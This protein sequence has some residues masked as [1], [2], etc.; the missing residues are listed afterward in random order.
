MKSQ[1]RWFSAA[2]RFKASAERS[3]QKAKSRTFGAGLRGCKF[4]TLEQRAML[5]TSPNI[6]LVMT[7]DQRLDTMFAMPIT[8]QLIGG[9]GTT[10]ENA[11]TVTSLCCPSRT[12]VFTGQYV[13][14]HGVVANDEPQ[15]GFEGFDDSSTLATWL[16]DAGYRTG[17]YGKF[18]NG[19]YATSPRNADPNNMY[20]PPGWDEWHAFLGSS[21]Y[22]FDLSENGVYTTYP[23]ANYSTDV[24]RDK[25]ADFIESGESNDD[26]PFFLYYSVKAPHTPANPAQRH[27]FEFDDIE[28]YRPPSFN[29]ADVSDKPAF[30][31]NQAPLTQAEIDAIDAFRENQ[32]ESLL[33]VDEAVGHLVETLQANGEWDNTIFVFMSDSGIQWGE[34]RWDVKGTGYEETIRIPMIIRDGRDPVQRTSDP[35]ALTIDIA[36]TLLEY[37][38]ISVSDHIDGQSLVPLISGQNPTWRNDFIV[39]HLDIG[40]QPPFVTLRSGDWSYMEY[41][42]GERE[43]YDLSADPYQ[44]QSLH[45]NPAYATVM[46]QLSARMAQLR[47][48]DT[49][50][51][52][53]TN[54]SVTPN[55]TNEGAV[56]IKAT[57][58]DI[59]TGGSEVRMPTFHIDSLGGIPQGFAMYPDDGLFDS[60]TENVTAVLTPEAFAALSVGTHTIYVRGRDTAG[61]WS[62]AVTATFIK[63]AEAPTQSYVSVSPLSIAHPE[64]STGFVEYQYTLTRTGVVTGTSTVD[65]T[66]FGSGSSPANTD[67][68]G[69]MFPIGTVTFAPGETTKSLVL[70]LAGDTV[71]ELDETFQVVFSNPSANTN[72]QTTSVGGII[73][74]DETLASTQGL[75]GEYFN[76]VALTEFVST[77]TDPTVNFTSGWNGGPPGTGVTADQNYS[78]RWSGEVEV[79]ASGA[80]TF[81]TTTNDGV[82]LWIDDQMVI[83]DWNIHIALENSATVNLTAGWHR[84][85]MEYFQRGGGAVATLSFAGPGQ[86]KAVIPQSRLRTAS[87]PV[88]VAPVFAIAAA[89]ASK[90]EGNADFTP[91]SFTVTRTENTT[92]S[93]T[94]DY[95]VT[96]S[97]GNAAD[98]ADFGG[99]LPSGTLAFA[100]GETSKTITILVSG[101][102]T[103]EGDETFTVV[104][105]N[106]SGDAEISTESAT[107]TIVNDDAAPVPMQPGLK[108]EYFNS[109]NLTNLATTRVDQSINFTTGWNSTPP[110]TTVTGD[111]NYSV[112]W[113]GQVETPTAGSWT[114]FTTSNDGIRLWID[115]QLVIDNWT[116]H[117]ATENSGTLNLNAGW[118]SIRLEYF[119]QGGAAV[120]TLS[121]QGPDQSKVLIPTSHLRT[122]TETPT[123]TPTGDGLEGQYYNST[124]LTGLVSTRVDSTVNFT[125]GWNASPSGSGVTADAQY[126]VR[127]TGYVETSAAGDWT[128]FTT[129]NDGVRLWI[130][131][132]LV[133]NNWTTHAATENSGSV[134][135]GAGWHSIRLEY[136]Q[137]GGAAIIT[138]SYQGPGQTKTIIPQSRL[139]STLPGAPMVLQVLSYSGEEQIDQPYVAQALSDPNGSTPSGPLLLEASANQA[140][141]ADLRKVRTSRRDSFR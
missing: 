11:Y 96:S 46:S 135:L 82:R 92:G 134:S 133:I 109:I 65:F 75:K 141:L 33:A 67:D 28:P 99:S 140:L 4:E 97:G 102:T 61:N 52:Q 95:Q 80:W 132:Q 45:N 24:L 139:S 7:D 21:F 9:T 57:V 26:Q 137:Q 87:I 13:H 79:A 131:D 53:I 5:A 77:R 2:A 121:F 129:S 108:G 16:Q 128:F 122:A 117:V 126:S 10:F 101:D 86:T 12:S 104:L 106:A 63:T 115:D 49:Q 71:P 64:G 58:S 110:G 93:L 56:T 50:A 60:V 6:V 15:G 54:V 118:H 20:V 23:G 51:P 30:V 22:D 94:V 1:R 43:L 114:F 130:N 48:Q 37:A 31:Q 62:T 91:Y 85:R 83:D 103:F 113:T 125:A 70:L 8:Q 100:P 111:A 123:P 72:L 112:R 39:E 18:L 14:N 27:R 105:L 55:L 119:Q 19:Y 89:S 17:L 35:F 116:A 3:R 90:A 78:I 107:G 38:G 34:H 68:F 59:N 74:N 136:F 120:A 69:G 44:M 36:P 42:T 124:D 29:E 40:G 98:V 84:I 81:Y 88:P 73:L 76:D 25:A 66:V 127:W 138:L 32:L 41:N 47:S